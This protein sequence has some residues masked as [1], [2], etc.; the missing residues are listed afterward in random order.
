MRNKSTFSKL[1]ER[2]KP[3]SFFVVLSM[4]L[5]LFS[6]ILTLVIPLK[7]GQAIDCI[8]DKTNWGK[9]IPVFTQVIILSV[10]VMILQWV[11]NLINN[12]I[13]YYVV[14]DLRNDAI[15]KIETLP[16]SYIDSHSQGDIV[17]RIIADAD[18]FADGLLMGFTQA[19]SGVVTIIGTLIFM[20]RMSISITLVVVLLTPLS[21]F[22]ASFISKKTFNMFKLQSETRGEQTAFIDEM[23]SN[24]KVVKAFS[25]EEQTI[26]KFASMNED[27]KN[28]S[29]KAIFFSS[30]TNPMTRFVYNVIYAFV[31]L[32]G[33]IGVISGNMSIGILTCMLSYVN[34]YTK[35]FNEITGVITELQN[36]FACIERIF[37]L[38]NE[39]S[40]PLD[41]FDAVCLNDLE[42]NIEIKDVFFSYNKEKKLIEDFNLSVKKGQKVAIVGPTGAGKSTI[43]NLL[44]RY[45]DTDKGIISVDGYDI[46]D[47][48]RESL[49]SNYGM[50]LQETWLRN[51]TIRDNICLGKPDASE[52]EILRAA[53]SSHA[54]SFIRRLENGYDT[55]ISDDGGS[56]SQG[57]KQLLCIARI[58]LLLPPMLILDEATSSIDTRTEKKI[59]SAFNMLMEG[60]TSFIIAHRLSTIKNADIILVMKDGHII[61]S[62]NHE[63]LIEKEGFYYN[64]YN[65]QYGD[66]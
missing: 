38:L 26:E 60:K 32:F 65:S 42:G 10:I 1:L 9:I 50:V 59:Q 13:T 30:L 16:L 45:Y 4:L 64:L 19:F 12:K 11:M 18:Q 55:I 6:V 44:M 3:Y 25:R 36:A 52:E 56:L 5:A 48:Q 41:K 28:A 20:I 24:E 7:I 8:G 66:R 14:R 2:I 27:L 54:H 35:P 22:V 51:G 47:I 31:A 58:M 61:E 34:Q 23:I 43:I 33:A 63:S 21:L 57:Q 49:R 53:K 62:G 29:L 46:K 40:E 17:S 37:E 39:K 15:Q